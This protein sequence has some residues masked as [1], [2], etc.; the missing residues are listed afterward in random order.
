MMAVPSSSSPSGATY[1]SPPPY[2]GPLATR[3]RFDDRNV[4]HQRLE[5]VGLLAPVPT[6]DEGRRRIWR[7]GSSGVRKGG[8]WLMAQLVSGRRCYFSESSR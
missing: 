5:R 8:A 2:R 6:R 4:R 7:R 1:G 3:V